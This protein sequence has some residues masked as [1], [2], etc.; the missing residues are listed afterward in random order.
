MDLTTSIVELKV[1]VLGSF[2]Q[3]FLQFA[4]PSPN[5]A[6]CVDIPLLIDCLAICLFQFS[7]LFLY[8]LCGHLIQVLVHL[9]FFMAKSK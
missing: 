8:F 7:D 9:A 5:D 6:K 4:D 2:L 1:G 3:F